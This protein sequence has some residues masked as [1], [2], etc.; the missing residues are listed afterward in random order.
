MNQIVNTLPS[1]LARLSNWRTVSHDGILLGAPSVIQQDHLRVLTILSNLKEGDVDPWLGATIDTIIR[2]STKFIVYLDD[3]LEINWWWVQRVN[4]DVINTVQ[5]RVSALESD[6]TFL[7]TKKPLNLRFW[8][9]SE[10]E[11]RRATARALRCLIAEAMAVALN[12]GTLEDCEKV[13][14]EAQRQIAVVK[15]QQARP[16]FAGWF[17]AAVAFIGAV[18]VLLNMFGAN[19]IESKQELWFARMWTQA[20][21]CGA[22]GALISAI[23]RTRTLDLE[24]A[25]GHRGL[26]IE[27]MARA[28]IGAGAGLLIFFALEAGILQSMLTDDESVQRGLRLFLC[29][30]GGA[31]ERIL[32]SLVGRAEKIIAEESK[33]PVKPGGASGSPAPITP[34]TSEQAVG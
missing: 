3:D 18:A 8:S 16:V 17:M 21:L 28:L 27:A 9:S 4:E 11:S 30:A 31:S 5:A 29:I 32:P 26:F 25:A 10:S 7:L 24:P 33:P 19:W 20:G 13:L 15:D 22:F 23:T 34:D 12:S 6:T 2:K 1:L 14:A